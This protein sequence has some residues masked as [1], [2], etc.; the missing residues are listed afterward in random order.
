M[1]V[2]RPTRPRSPRVLGP[3]FRL[4]GRMGIL[5][6]YEGTEVPTTLTVRPGRSRLDGLSPPQPRGRVM[7]ARCAAAAEAFR[8]RNGEGRTCSSGLLAFREHL[9]HTALINLSS[10]ARALS[11]QLALP[12]VTCRVGQRE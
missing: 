3:L 9:G 6:P 5:V 8:S 7:Q 11:D 4:L 10:L 12:L 1:V 2:C